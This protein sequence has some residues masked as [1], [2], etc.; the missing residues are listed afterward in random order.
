MKIPAESAPRGARSPLV[1]R[2]L[3]VAGIAALFIVGGRQAG[4]QLPVFAAW[5]QSLGVWG[6]L[7]FVLGYA[8]AVVAFIPGSV[9]TLAAGAIFG[10]GA[11]I[12]Y[13]L[14]GAVLGATLAFLVAR[15]AARSIVEERIGRSPRFAAVN[16]AVA[17][18]GRKVVLLLRLSPVVPFNVLNYALGVT[19]VR[20]ADYVVASV[21]MVPGTVL[22]VYY[23]TV[24]GTI[25]SAVSG[26][27]VPRGRGYYALL[28]AGL[29]A[30]LAAT[31]VIARAARRALRERDGLPAAAGAPQ[32]G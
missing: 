17:S 24:A 9:L 18:Q 31:A 20:F 32:R 14:A 7:V 29:A 23:G 3:V 6:P 8:V 13:A 21:G 30:T 22:Y 15:Y 12:A 1:V 27:G 16:D 25:A 5:V 10:L 4:A 11:G 28:A 19:R 26:S 2:L